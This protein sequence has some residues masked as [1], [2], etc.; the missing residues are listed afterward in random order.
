MWITKMLLKKKPY[1]VSQPYLFLARRSTQPAL[2]ING[3]GLRASGS[4]TLERVIL[5]GNTATAGGG[6]WLLGATLRNVLV[7][8]NV[9]STGGGLWI[10]GD[11]IL[12]QSTIAGNRGTHG[13]ALYVN[14]GTV[15]LRNSIVWGNRSPSDVG[16]S[17]LAANDAN[18]ASFFSLDHTLAEESP[19]AG[20]LVFNPLFAAPVAAADAPSAEGDY[21][22]HFL[23]PAIDAGDDA[24]AAGHTVDLAGQP[25]FTGTVDLGAYES[26]TPVADPPLTL[27]EQSGSFTFNHELSG[28]T[29]SLT[30]TGAT[31]IL[32][33]TRRRMGFPRRRR[34]FLR[35][36]H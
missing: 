2:G 36:D 25:R 8:G 33:R 20:G 15:I 29:F 11:P 35:R 27:T 12:E 4:V 31:S 19:L 22:L 21:T 3:G 26:S 9:A 1:S 32:C 7:A 17:Q 30:A 5:R 23:S 28:N 13:P 34:R 24:L 6:A 10:N 16:S 18:L 14:F